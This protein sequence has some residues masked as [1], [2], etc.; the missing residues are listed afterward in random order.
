MTPK[1]QAIKLID[2]LNAEARR[3]FV[4]GEDDKKNEI[5]N[6]IENIR[7][8]FGIVSEVADSTCES[9]Q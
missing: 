1:E 4:A 9:C 6:K 8:Q 2:I 7:K 5:L 3:F